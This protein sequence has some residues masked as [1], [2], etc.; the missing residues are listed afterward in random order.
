MAAIAPRIL[1]LKVTG[2]SLLFAYGEGGA[3]VKSPAFALTHL[4]F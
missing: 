4:P 2:S 3:F 1:S